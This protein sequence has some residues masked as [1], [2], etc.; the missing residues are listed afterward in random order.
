M[1]GRKSGISCPSTRAEE[2][3]VESFLFMLVQH[4]GFVWHWPRTSKTY[5]RDWISICCRLPIHYRGRKPR[6]QNT[7]NSVPRQPWLLRERHLVSVL[8]GPPAEYHQYDRHSRTAL[9]LFDSHSLPMV[10]DESFAWKLLI[11][12]LAISRFENLGVHL[13]PLWWTTR[14]SRFITEKAE[15][16][17]KE[18]ARW[19]DVS[20]TIW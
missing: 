16:F 2:R 9:V 18:G 6:A 20:R 11:R 15:L 14:C 1:R 19:P 8:I 17:P 10:N 5:S 12:L 4:A 3:R 13:L 7:H